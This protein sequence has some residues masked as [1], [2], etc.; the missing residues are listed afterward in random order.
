MQET[1]PRPCP[2][3]RTMQPHCSDPP[4][5]LSALEETVERRSGRLPHGVAVVVLC[6][7]ALVVLAAVALAWPLRELVPFVPSATPDGVVLS[8]QLSPLLVGAWLGSVA[9]HGGYRLPTIGSGRAE[10]RSMVTASVEV[11]SSS[12]SPTSSTPPVHGW[13]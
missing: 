13:R 5:P 10:P 2:A 12:S 3:Q 6:L 7:D 1:V 9:L 8:L 11:S 4:A